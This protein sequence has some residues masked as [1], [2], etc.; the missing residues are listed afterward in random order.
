MDPFSPITILN[1]LLRKITDSEAP[2][3]QNRSNPQND[4]GQLSFPSDHQD[5]T[6]DS[7]ILYVI[8]EHWKELQEN[9]GKIDT[10]VAS[11][12]AAALGTLRIPLLELGVN[13]DVDGGL[14]FEDAEQQVKW[15]EYR[16]E[17]KGK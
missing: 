9:V 5:L 8:S 10:K 13:V 4:S 2:R 3:H 16:R 17:E 1:K 15:D 6:Y 14:A 12:A 7:D 11:R